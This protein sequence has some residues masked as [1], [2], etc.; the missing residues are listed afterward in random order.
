MTDFERLLSQQSPDASVVMTPDGQVLHW[1]KGAEAMFGYSS[2]DSLGRCYIDLIIPP[3]ETDQERGFLGEALVKEHL[4]REIL[5]QRR[6][7]SLLYVAITL[8]V[9]Q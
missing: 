2:V 8:A 5:C 3:S 6:D 4:S 9:A 7:G 1:S